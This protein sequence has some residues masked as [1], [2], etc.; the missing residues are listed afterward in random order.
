MQT[1]KTS[2]KSNAY[3]SQKDNSHGRM[4][5]S[6]TTVHRKIKQILNGVKVLID[7]EMDSIFSLSHIAIQS[8]A[9]GTVTLRVIRQTKFY[10]GSKNMYDCRNKAG[11]N[12]WGDKSIVSIGCALKPEMLFATLFTVSILNY[13]FFFMVLSHLGEKIIL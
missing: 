6:Y 1:K 2:N 5:S 12:L 4:H 3:S 10:H 13:Y 9:W 11:S 8:A 7:I